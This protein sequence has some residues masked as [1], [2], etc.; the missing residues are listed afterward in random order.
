MGLFTTSW[1]MSQFERFPPLK[2]RSPANQFE[3][4][5]TPGRQTSSSSLLSSDCSR[6]ANINCRLLFRQEI[7]WAFVLALAKAGSNRPARMAIMAITTNNSISVNPILEKLRLERSGVRVFITIPGYYAFAQKSNSSGF[8]LL[9]HDNRT[10]LTPSTVSLAPLT[11]GR[12]D[13][14]LAGPRTVRFAAH[15]Q[16]KALTFLQSASTC[17]HSADGDRPR[18]RSSIRFAQGFFCR[19]CPP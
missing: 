5:G 2:S 18:S 1:L 17:R 7:P 8:R 16:H 13:T 9:N 3:R 11:N 10:K 15:G 4:P 12:I 14:A 19:G 6:Q